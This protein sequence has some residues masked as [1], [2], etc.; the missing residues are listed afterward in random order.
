MGN[1]KGASHEPIDGDPDS[2]ESKIF[3]V[4]SSSLSEISGDWVRRRVK[5]SFGGDGQ[6]LTYNRIAMRG[7]EVDLSPVDFFPVGS[8]QCEDTAA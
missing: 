3:R 2:Q 5:P 1:N 4:R 8:P 6:I 7:E